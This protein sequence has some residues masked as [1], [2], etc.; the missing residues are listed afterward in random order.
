[1]IIFIDE[2]FIF[3]IKINK[4]LKYYKFMKKIFFFLT[5][6]FNISDTKWSIPFKF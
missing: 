4:N 2:Y 5:L 3:F 6:E 1:M